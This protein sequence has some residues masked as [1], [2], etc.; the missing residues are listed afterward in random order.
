MNQ[1]VAFGTLGLSLSCTP[2]YLDT[3]A[4]SDA[5]F[6]VSCVASCGVAGLDSGLL[7][8]ASFSGGTR[9]YALCCEHRAALMAQLQTIEDLWCDGLEVPDKTIGGLVV[10]AVVS[11][12]TGARGATIDDGEGYVAFNCGAWLGELIS[13]LK[14]TPC[15]QP[16]APR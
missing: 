12:V 1:L 8:E 6:E 9:Q 4:P 5:A 15:C 11:E 10:G 16:D 2:A 3:V 7:I 13:E 14:R